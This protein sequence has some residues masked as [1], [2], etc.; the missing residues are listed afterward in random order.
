MAHP[1]DPGVVPADLETDN[2][3]GR[4][5]EL[6]KGARHVREDIGPGDREHG[7]GG[8][9]QAITMLRRVSVDPGGEGVTDWLGTPGFAPR[10]RSPLAPICP[11]AG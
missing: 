4:G 5:H 6:G 1:F 11:S 10:T 7:R 2:A 3:A 8:A 9:I